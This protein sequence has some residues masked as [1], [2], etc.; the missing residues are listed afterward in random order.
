MSDQYHPRGF[1]HVLGYLTWMDSADTDILHL[2]MMGSHVVVLS[3]SDIATD[4]LE[5]RGVVY[6]D[7]VRKPFDIPLTASALTSTHFQPRLPMVNELY[8][9][10]GSSLTTPT[11]NHLH[12]DGV[13]LGRVANALRESLAY[14]SSAIPP[15]LQHLNCESVR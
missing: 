2:D 6:G 15:F 10:A 7:R 4:L 11:N 3:S 12:Q 1:T 9:L 14:Q 8:V 5:R 13:H